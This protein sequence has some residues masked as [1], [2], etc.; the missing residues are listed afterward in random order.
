MIEMGGVVEMVDDNFVHFS[1]LK[2]LNV[3]MSSRWSAEQMLLIWIYLFAGSSL[4]DN[5]ATTLKCSGDISDGRLFF[6][7]LLI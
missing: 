1:L 4:Y 5:F 2:R 6:P 7:S 3:D